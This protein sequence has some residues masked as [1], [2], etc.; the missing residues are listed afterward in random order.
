MI[1]TPLLLLLPMAN[2]LRVFEEMDL[3]RL[4]YNTES[5]MGVAIVAVCEA[6]W[7]LVVNNREK[8]LLAFI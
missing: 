6:D 7:K 8:Y 4:I 2:I 3:L 5:M 1:Y